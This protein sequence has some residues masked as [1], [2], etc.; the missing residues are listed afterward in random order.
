M[1]KKLKKELELDWEEEPIK[2]DI[3]RDPQEF[4]ED[5]GFL[6]HPKL[7]DENNQPLV[8]RKLAPYQCEFWKYPSNALA[9]KSQK[10]GLTTSTLMEDFQYTLLPEGAGKDVLIIAQTLQLADDHI[11]TLKYMIH[12]SKKYSQFLITNP[13]IFREEKTNASVIFVKNPYNEKRPSRIIGLGKSESSV[14][15][16]KN[17]GKV[18]MS[19]VAKLDMKEQKNFFAAVYSRLANTEGVVKIET[20]PNG[21]QGEVFNIYNKSKIKCEIDPVISDMFADDP[22]D[23][24]SKFKIFEYP[25]RLA[26]NAGIISQE[27]LDKERHHLGEALFSQLYNCGFLPPGNQWYNQSMIFYADYGVCA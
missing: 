14:W 10:I 5:F 9:I 12:N 27:F 18:H 22:Q 23:N 16:W 17:V 8:V 15:S 7:K 4:Y 11:R 25:A 3:P 24:G 6:Y 13:E 2:L 20:P 21:Q 1:F 19:D 26:V